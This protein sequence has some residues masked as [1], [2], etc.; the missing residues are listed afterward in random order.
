MR[1]N[2]RKFFFNEKLHHRAPMRIKLL[3]WLTRKAWNPEAKWTKVLLTNSTLTRPSLPM[4]LLKKSSTGKNRKGCWKWMIVN[5]RTTKSMKRLSW[6]TNKLKPIKS[7]SKLLLPLFFCGLII[8]VFADSAA[9]I[10]CRISNDSLDLISF[11][12]N[13]HFPFH[14]L[15]FSFL[16]FW[17]DEML[18]END[19]LKHFLVTH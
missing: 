7:K 18:V 14:F 1:K 8:L 5:G 16:L 6:L 4:L 10:Q 13:I 11:V 17:M 2:K 3:A 15:Y 19:I 9:M 12:Q